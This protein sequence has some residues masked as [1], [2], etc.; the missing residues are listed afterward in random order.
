M[1]EGMITFCRDIGNIAK[2]WLN[3]A[4]KMFPPKWEPTGTGGN[5]GGNIYPGITRATPWD[6]RMSRKRP[7]GVTTAK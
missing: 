7:S 4:D 3:Q 6:F 2:I 5:I 1:I